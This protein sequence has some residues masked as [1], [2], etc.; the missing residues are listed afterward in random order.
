MSDSN[1]GKGIASLGRD[2]AFLCAVLLACLAGLGLGYLEGKQSDGRES[3]T[4]EYEQAAKRNAEIACNN[5]E[6]GAIADCIYNEISSA[7]E[8]SESEQDLDAQQWMARWAMLLTIITAFT[9]LISWIALRYLRDTFQQTAKGAK[10]AAD[11]S[12][13][14]EEANA[15]TRKLVEADLQPY[16]FFEKTVITE[17]NG[18]SIVVDDEGETIVSPHEG[19][20]ELYIRNNGRVIAR[21]LHISLKHYLID[22]HSIKFS[23]YRCH[24]LDL[25]VCAPNHTRE[26][27]F[28]YIVPKSKTLDF[29]RG[30]VSCILRVRLTFENDAGEKF[31][32]KGQFILPNSGAKRALLLTSRDTERMRKQAKKRREAQK[33]L[34]DKH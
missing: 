27:F 11:A 7:R 19:M 14:M 30:Y 24:R 2:T 31:I 20:V 17:I 32:E 15:L 18:P 34:F 10:A 16:L 29:C 5:L 26:A 3:R 28:S 22:W 23:N 4:Y 12:A 9:T 21:N 6:A 33:G 25:S 13:R 1:R 8:Q